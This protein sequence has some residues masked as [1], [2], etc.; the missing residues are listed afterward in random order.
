MPRGQRQLHFHIGI[1]CGCAER[2]QWLCGR[3]ERF[4]NGYPSKT[5]RAHSNHNHVGWGVHCA[6]ALAFSLFQSTKYRAVDAALPREPWLRSVTMPPSANGELSP[7]FAAR[8]V[9]PPPAALAASSWRASSGSAARWSF[10]HQSQTWPLTN[11]R[12]RALRI[13]GGQASVPTAR[14]RCQR[15]GLGANGQE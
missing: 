12:P 8:S 1:G 2:R 11:H 13:Q 7:V 6:P 14:P 5:P 4:Q 3:H 15:P 9:N 10:C